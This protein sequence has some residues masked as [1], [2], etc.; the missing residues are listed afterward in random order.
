MDRY[1]L[2]IR[3]MAKQTSQTK[4]GTT[5]TPR[6]WRGTLN[7]P[8]TL[9]AKTSGPPIRPRTGMNRDGTFAGRVSPG[10]QRPGSAGTQPDR[11]ASR[12]AS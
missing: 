12:N 4:T 8:A 5:Q 2:V 9:V 10:S 1:P 7:M 3:K 6:S 11:M